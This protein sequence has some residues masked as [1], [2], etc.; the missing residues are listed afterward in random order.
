[1]SDELV[2]SNA[3]VVLPEA[4]ITGTVV[5][6]DGLIAEVSEGTAATGEDLRGDYLL[7][8]FVELHTDHLASHFKPRPGTEWNPVPAVLAH[9]TQVSGA[10]VTTVFDAIRIGRIPHLDDGGID[11][12]EAAQ[13]LAVAIEHAAR[14]DITRAE[15]FI[16]VRCEVCSP[17]VQEELA[18][19][20]NLSAVALLSLM[21]HTPGQ[22][23]YADVESFRKYLRAGGDS[24]A[25]D[26]ITERM[27]LQQASAAMHSA[28]NRQAIADY[29]N[30]H[31]I[32]LAAHD[33]TT[34]EHVEEAAALGVQISEFPTTA[35]AA[36]AAHERGQTVVMGA[37]NIVR[38][39]SHSN[40]V[41][42]AELLELGLLDVL[43]SDYVPASPLQAIFQL[44]EQDKLA[45]EDGAALVAGNPARAVGLTDRGEIAVG[46]RADLVRVNSH[47]LP[48]GQHV[49]VVR[50]V[51]RG[52]VRVS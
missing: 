26:G 9:D 29:A 18:K 30:A 12:P 42:A 10:G 15:H 40:N 27:K 48:G 39:G 17:T 25:A 8:G 2:L 24:A 28:K 33:D 23:Q 43:S 3:R 47:R 11:M 1:M 22:R 4:V 16:H 7:P 38:G 5:L 44:A 35:T 50:A 36:R 41:A 45:L 32:T 51:Y 34:T 19:L 52:G 46:Q 14:A 20:E 6:R 31:Q 49:P 37:P 21:D 13:T